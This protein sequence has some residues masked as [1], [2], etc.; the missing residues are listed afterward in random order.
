MTISP[1]FSSPLISSLPSGTKQ[2]GIRAPS[3]RVPQ[4]PQEPL[5]S[6][7]APTTQALKSA[8][9][10]PAQPTRTA[11]WASCTFPPR[12]ALAS[13]PATV[14]QCSASV[15]AARLVLTSGN[16]VHNGLNGQAGFFN[17][18]VFIPAFRDGN[19]PFGPSSG[20]WH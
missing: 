3:P 16:C 14:Y 5:A 2:L 20:H 15:I 6:P 8:H 19:V 1:A 10:L 12:R 7:R 18:F 9:S 13:P 11:R 17:N 4:T